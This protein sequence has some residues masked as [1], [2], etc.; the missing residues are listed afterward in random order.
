MKVPIRA[1]CLAAACGASEHA[2]VAES[3]HG[4]EELD[5]RE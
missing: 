2:L 1:C 3:H 5:Q 4:V